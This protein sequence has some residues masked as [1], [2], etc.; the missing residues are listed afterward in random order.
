MKNYEVFYLLT[1]IFILAAGILHFV[2]LILKVERELNI[3]FMIVTLPALIAYG[4]GTVLFFQISMYWFFY[5]RNSDLRS[6]RKANW[7]RM[8][9]VQRGLGFFAL[10]VLTLGSLITQLMLALKFDLIKKYTFTESLLPVLLAFGI[11]SVIFIIAV[12]TGGLSIP[13]FVARHPRIK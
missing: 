12:Y 8:P 4:L 10:F 11:S 5:S 1:V 3:S 6:R 9:K 13:F 7:V 2:L